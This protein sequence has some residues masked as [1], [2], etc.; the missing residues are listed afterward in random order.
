[1]LKKYKL[2]QSIA[3]KKGIIRPRDLD[4]YQ[5]PREYLSRF[6][7]QGQLEKIGRGLYILPDLEI[8]ENF[9]LAQVSK[10]V[11]NGIISL[12]SALRFHHLTTQLPYQ[13]WI[14]IP[15]KSHQ[16]LLQEVSLRVVHFS[17][18]A[19]S[20]GIEAFMISGVK[21]PIYN[22]AK[23]VADCFKYRNKIGLDVALEALREYW[24]KPASSL[25][26]IWHYSKIC[27]V[28]NI[29]KPYMESLA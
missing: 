15:N 27:R 6:Y 28:T 11:P 9:S 22:P 16:P 18:K 13:V 23:T 19:L 14:A 25:D 17:G 7:Q 1:M 29:I 20:A 10:S 2:I 5:I 21:V 26:E 4:E 3:K 8:D 24:L 12:L